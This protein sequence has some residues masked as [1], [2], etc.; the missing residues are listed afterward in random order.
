MKYELNKH[1]KLC[2]FKNLPF[3]MV[4]NLRASYS[5][6]TKDE[7]EFL[8]RCAAHN[9]ID[10]DKLE[11]KDKRMLDLLLKEEILVEAGPNAAPIVPEYLSYPN[12]M[13]KDI[14]WSI[15]GKCN[16]KCKHC[17]Q[18]AP[19]AVFGEPT[20]EQCFDLIKQMKECGI[21]SVGITGGEP[22]IRKDF[23]QIIDAL[24]EADIKVTTIYSNGWLI[25]EALLDQFEKR[26]IKP[27]W[28]ISFDG[29]GCH[30]DFR[31][32][33]GAEEHAVKAIKLLIS[34]GYRVGAA[35][36][37]YQGNKD[38]FVET[39]K[40]LGAL[41]VQYVKTGYTAPQG[42]YLDHPELHLTAAE[43]LEWYKKNIPAYIKAGRPV[44]V[45][46]EGLFQGFSDSELE[47]RKR[48][49]PNSPMD[50]NKA[51]ECADC[52]CCTD[53]DCNKGKEQKPY[54][55]MMLDR[56]LPEEIA[57]KKD[58]CGVLRQHFYISPQ[59]NVLPCMSIDGL[60]AGEK[61]PNV[62]ESSLQD[63]LTDSWYITA[64]DF[65]VR[66]Y[67]AK[68]PECVDCD[69]KLKCLAGCR[70]MA[71]LGDD[72][73]YLALDQRTCMIAK[74]DWAGQIQK[75]IDKMEQNQ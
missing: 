48:S 11:Q 42:E 14:Q 53:E 18:S 16:F 46:F 38:A 2:G 58:V 54:F 68:R 5:F 4:D 19:H 15:T 13:R 40:F 55:F 71:L 61:F 69:L 30:D 22:L 57:L 50:A 8:Y 26:N 75:E 29:V 60:P 72:P 74:E 49:M 28:Q 32:I 62:Y 6:F 64:T 56:D 21:L 9:D 39:M 23:W 45:Q 67:W 10:K 17:F 51:P 44:T 31:G 3:G 1:I 27:A 52:A 35:Y 73:D 7:F 34:R 37:I 59:G 25:N 36:S 47:M 43:E 63:I 20:L 41:G 12:H 65:R 33:P 24:I 70:A 66:D